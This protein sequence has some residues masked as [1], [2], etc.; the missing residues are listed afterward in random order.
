M[1]HADILSLY[2]IISLS[3]VALTS[4]AFSAFEAA[5]HLRG[6]RYH[7]QNIEELYRD[8]MQR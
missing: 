3:F 6:I 4:I 7:L 5:R 1:T 2:I 8:W